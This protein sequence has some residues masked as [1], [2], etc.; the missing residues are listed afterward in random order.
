M[1]RGVA[2][3][4][5][6]IIGKPLEGLRELNYVTGPRIRSSVYRLAEERGYT[7]TLVNLRRSYFDEQLKARRPKMASME[8]V[9]YP[10]YGL[11]GYLKTLLRSEW[12][13]DLL[14]VLE[15]K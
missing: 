10:V 12:N 13:I 14:V 4:Y 11:Y 7:L 1:P 5:L 3:V 9:L 8:G 2:R 15:K 6:R